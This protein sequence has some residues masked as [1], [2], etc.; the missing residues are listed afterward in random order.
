MNRWGP[1]SALALAAVLLLAGCGGDCGLDDDDVVKPILMDLQT[2]AFC[3]LHAVVTDCL[4]V[5]RAVGDGAQIFEKGQDI[6]RFQLL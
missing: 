5:A 4:R 3:K 1:M 2:A 6:L